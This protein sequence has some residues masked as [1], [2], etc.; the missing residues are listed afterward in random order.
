MWPGDVYFPDFNHYNASEL[1]HK[2][3]MDWQK[4]YGILPSGIWIDMNE[5]ANFV[6]GEK[7]EKKRLNPSVVV[8]EDL[9]WDANGGINL[10]AHGVAI[11]ALH[12]GNGR[13]FKGYEFV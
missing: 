7:A 11:D 6:D 10:E 12:S 5:L 1:W 4:N 2:C 8:L 13:Y 9:P 3:Q